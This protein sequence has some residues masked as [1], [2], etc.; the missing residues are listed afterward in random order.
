MMNRTTK[1]QRLN[2]TDDQWI[3]QAIKVYG[4]YHNQPC[5]T[6]S[7]KAGPFIHLRNVNGV[8]ATFKVGPSGKL[9]QVATLT[10]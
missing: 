2:W 9:T 7:T 4:A 3:A 6:R 8:L 10:Q 1:E 5:T